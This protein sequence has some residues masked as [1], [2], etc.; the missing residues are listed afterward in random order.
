MGQNK[1]QAGTALMCV[2]GALIFA[3]TSFWPLALF[4]RF[5]IGVGSSGA[6]ISCT[7]VIR[8]WAPEKYFSIFISLSV[9][10]GLLS[11]HQ[12]GTLTSF[13]MDLFGW[14]KA[15]FY[16]G[17]SGVL[18]FV[19]LI[20]LVKNNP[21][22]GND[23]K[24]PSF[25][26]AFLTRLKNHLLSKKIIWIGLWGAFLTGPLYVLGDV[27][28]ISYMMRVF[29]WGK[30]QATQASTIIYFG[31]ACGGPVVAALS[32]KF[33]HYR[34][35][36]IA[37]LAFLMAGILGTEMWIKPSYEVVLGLNFL[38]GVFCSYQ[39]PCV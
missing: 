22:H 20:S 29:E 24:F 12:A 37:L 11:A 6:F 28:G 35:E 2:V 23:E 19:L 36:A 34:K 16:L 9:A 10:I 32:E 15:V 1:L 38:L 3:S 8:S 14:Q 4:A 26:K 7:K 17:I 39:N 27:W 21:S 31:M 25:N 18:L 30:D 13:L 5:L 33:Y